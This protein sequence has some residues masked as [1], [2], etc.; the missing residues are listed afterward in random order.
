MQRYNPQQKQVLIYLNLTIRLLTKYMGSLKTWFLKG[1][2]FSGECF[3]PSNMQFSIRILQLLRLLRPSS[4]GPLS[5]ISLEKKRRENTPFLS[6]DLTLK[7][8]YIENTILL[9]TM[10][11]YWI[12]MW[13]SGTCHL[14]NEMEATKHPYTRLN[15]NCEKIIGILKISPF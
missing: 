15:A 8:Q 5:T 14:K 3:E 12:W 2:V 11:G 10:S 9:Q 7:N 6:T 4:P 13:W 1:R